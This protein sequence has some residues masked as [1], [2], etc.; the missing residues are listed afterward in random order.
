MSSTAVIVES[1]FVLI[2]LVSK[3]AEANNIKE[4]ELHAKLKEAF[5][6]A[7]KRDPKDLPDV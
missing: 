4:E 1:I 2:S 7:K 3:L 5:A 6:E